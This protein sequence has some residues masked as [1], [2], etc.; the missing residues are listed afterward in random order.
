[1]SYFFNLLINLGISSG[2]CWASASNTIIYILPFLIAKSQPV[3]KVAP[4][5]KLIMCL[6]TTAL[7]F[8]ATSLVLSLL[9][10]STTIILPTYLFVFLIMLTILLSSLYAGIMANIL[11]GFIFKMHLCYLVQINFLSHRFLYHILEID[12][13]NPHTP[14]LLLNFPL[15]NQ[16]CIHKYLC[17]SIRAGGSI[18]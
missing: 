10:S 3:F 15:P 8:S 17:L 6:S 14:P 12:L 1:M 16:P 7:A 11:F 18:I 4:L 2:L 13:K 9:P 5:P